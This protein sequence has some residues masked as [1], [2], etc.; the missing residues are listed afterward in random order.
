MTK[1]EKIA[2]ALALLAMAQPATAGVRE[3][4][5]ASAGD[6][7]GVR[8]GVFAGATYRMALDGR[9]DRRNG[10]TTLQVAGFAAAPGR[11][12]MQLGSGIE[13]GRGANGTARLSIAGVPAGQIGKRLNMSGGAKTALIVGGVVLLAAGAAVVIGAHEWKNSDILGDG[14]FD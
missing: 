1:I 7:A 3:A 9:S 6:H 2:T 5:F 12:G 11:T 10:Q 13:L 14:N 8:T 4:A